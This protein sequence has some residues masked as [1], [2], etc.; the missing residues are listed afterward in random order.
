MCL[1]LGGHLDAN[2][3]P[4]VILTLVGSEDRN[5]GS[6]ERMDENMAGI[7]S[8]SGI[9]CAATN[10]LIPIPSKSRNYTCM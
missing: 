9:A 8:T 3:N 6:R 5:F 1:G 7:P 4:T 10:M 2:L